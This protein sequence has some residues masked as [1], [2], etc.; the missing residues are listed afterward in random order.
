MALV[1]LSSPAQGE[2]S[3]Q[4]QQQPQDSQPP[5]DPRSGYWSK[6]D[7][8]PNLVAAALAPLRPAGS[9]APTGFEDQISD[10][11]A[12]LIRGAVEGSILY[13]PDAEGASTKVP[14]SSP[15]GEDFK[16]SA[17]AVGREAVVGFPQL[18]SWKDTP[19]GVGGL[20]ISA[21]PS[22]TNRRAKKKT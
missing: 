3:G 15:E 16:G 5:R 14:P 7:E 19:Q 10:A 6:I 12:V 4:A 1:P 21:L 11:D 8:T 13:E 17:E 18:D 20:H 2:P 22:A 9:R